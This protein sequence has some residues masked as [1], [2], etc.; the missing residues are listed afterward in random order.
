MHPIS[1]HPGRLIAYLAAWLPVAGLLSTLVHLQQ[2]LD[3]LPAAVLTVPLTLLYASICLSAWYLVSFFPVGRLG[4]SRFVP[5]YFLAALASALLW[6]GLG[7]LFAGGLDRVVAGGEFVRALNGS[8]LLFLSMGLV[9][10]ISATA[11]HY[12]LRAAEESS[13]ASQR[14]LQLEILA[15]EAQIKALKMQISPHFL[16][17]S[18]NSISALTSRD[19]AAARRMCLLLAAFFR[20][21]L[22]LGTRDRIAVE[23]EINLLHDFIGIEKVRFGARLDVDFH[24]EK[25]ALQCLIP[26]LILQPLVENG[27]NHGIAHML[28]GGRVSVTAKRGPEKLSVTVQNDYD[29]EA[30]VECGEGVGLR[31]VRE[32]LASAFGSDFHLSVSDD[33]SI[34]RVHL[35]IPAQTPA[36][37]AAERRAAEAVEKADA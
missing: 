33:N 11:V 10:H 9:L 15:R 8:A 36:R 4:V 23:E 3:W 21:T 25:A 1:G 27:I 22:A 16:F 13:E 34:F 32:R 31:N 12:T 35:T 17:N 24:V 37:S 5:L 6:L 7:R 28:E 19:P 14:A 26:P 2:T 29:P 18:L 30:A 20:R